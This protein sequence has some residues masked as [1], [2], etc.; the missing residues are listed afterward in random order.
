MPQAEPKPVH[1]YSDKAAGVPAVLID[2]QGGGEAEKAI[3]YH[4]HDDIAAEEAAA[5]A[6]AE[7]GFTATP[8]GDASSLSDYDDDE[9]VK[10]PERNYESNAYDEVAA[11]EEYLAHLEAEGEGGSAVGVVEAIGMDSLRIE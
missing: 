9:P 6:A 2:K 11:D 8:E 5:V 7:L 4:D 1:D 10:R 3:E